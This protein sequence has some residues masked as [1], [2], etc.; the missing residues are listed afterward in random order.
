MEYRSHPLPENV[1][2]QAVRIEV[3]MNN[4]VFARNMQ[5]PLISSTTLC[6][7]AYAWV[8]GEHNR[9]GLLK[10]LSLCKFTASDVSLIAEIPF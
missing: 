1:F 5:G 2:T 6:F 7:A 8:S 3:V 9:Y 10:I 4:N